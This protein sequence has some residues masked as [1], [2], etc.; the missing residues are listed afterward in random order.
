VVTLSVCGSASATAAPQAAPPIVPKKRST[1]A[2]NEPP[3]LV[4]MT[5]TVVS[6]AQ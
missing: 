2:F 5:M 4:C 6:T 3:T 1:I